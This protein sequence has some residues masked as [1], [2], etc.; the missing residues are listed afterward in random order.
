MDSSEEVRYLI[1]AA[2]REG[3][4][5]L[6][7]MLR[8]LG[9]SPSQAEVLRVL[10]DLGPLALVDLGARLVCENGSPSRLVDGLVTAGLVE[11]IPSAEDRRRVRLSLTRDGTKKAR[12]VQRTEAEL[13]ELIGKVISAKDRVLVKGVLWDLVSGLPAGDALRLRIKSR[14]S[15]ES[16]EGL[17]PASRPSGRRMG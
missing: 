4:R 7:D 17:S 15:A 6:G 1:L 5:I 10:A 11:R 14:P 3:N 2:Q 8:P 13:H 16:P 9:L 12:A